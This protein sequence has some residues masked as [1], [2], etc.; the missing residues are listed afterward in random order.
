MPIFLKRV[1]RVARNNQV[2]NKIRYEIINKVPEFQR[3]S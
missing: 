2:I 1:S 3:E